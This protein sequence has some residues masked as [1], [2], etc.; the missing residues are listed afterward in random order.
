MINQLL[1]KVGA[2]RQRAK[3]KAAYEGALLSALADG[4]LSPE[5][6]QALDEFRAELGLTANDVR[7][8]RATAYRQAYQVAASDRR[9]TAAEA[10]DLERIKGYLGL[11]E[12]E[13]ATTQRDFH[14]LR[15]LAEIQDGNLPITSTPGLLLQKDER[16]HW[17]EPAQLIEERVIRRRYEG[18]SSGAS[19]RI[20]KG[21]TY[22]VGAPRGQL[23]TD[24]AAVPVSDGHFSLTNRRAVFK[25]TT[26]SFT[27][28]WDKVL[29]V[30][31]FSDG[32][33][34]A[35]GNGQSRLVKFSNN[36]DLEVMGAIMSQVVNQLNA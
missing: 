17:S 36:P 29:G 21:V 24:T 25:G 22:R 30:E 19:I 23:V 7:E 26:K 33:S 16:V 6:I 8:L 20:M 13:V 18:G 2:W 32:V 9:I 3:N 5:E 35:D 15:F 12:S 27:Y 31:L 34:L 11:S 4:S 10:A 1:E 14:R 28:K